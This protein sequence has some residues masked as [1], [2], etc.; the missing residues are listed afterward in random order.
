VMRNLGSATGAGSVPW[1]VPSF[2]P[3]GEAGAQPMR[4]E[5][6]GCPLG[7]IGSRKGEADKPN[8]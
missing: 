6:E 2:L 3:A 4:V 1:T 7:T 8:R 5:P